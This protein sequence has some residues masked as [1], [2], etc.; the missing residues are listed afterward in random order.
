MILFLWSCQSGQLEPALS[1]RQNYLKALREPSVQSVRSCEQ[2]LH[3]DLRGECVLFAAKS[4]VGERM[5][6]LSVCESAPTVLWKQAC[7]FE[8]ADSTGM[9]G[10]RAARVCAETGEFEI[11][12]LYHALQREEQSLAARF[13]KGKEL[14]L[15]EEIARRFQHKEELKNDKISE[16][17]PA[18]IIARR[19]FQRYVDNKKIRFSEDMCG[20]APREICTQAYR[21][22]IQMQKDREKKTFPK[23]CSIPMS[24]HQVQAAGFVLWEEGFILSALEAWENTCRQ[25]KEQRR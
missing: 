7:L 22:V 4:A 19:F 3:E 17:L 20:S 16:S 5:D 23:P 14:E 8:V 10:Q 18:K 9:T 21:F 24:D 6:A 1:D 13:P 11:R 2:I 25:N 15:I 12:C